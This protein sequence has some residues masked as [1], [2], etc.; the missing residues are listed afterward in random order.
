[1]SDDRQW[2]DRGLDAQPPALAERVRLFRLLVHDAALLRQ[3]LDRALAP[4]GL[5]TQQGALLQW[6]EAQP[7]APTIGA[8]ALA[9]GMTHQ[10]VKQIVTALERKG[11]IDITVD[12][13]DRRARRL[14]LTTHHRQFWKQRN[15]D[16]FAAVATWTAAWS[17]DEVS[18][19]V[20]LLRRLSRSL[21]SKPGGAEP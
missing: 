21:K 17:D 2:L 10:N 7:A 15:P 4:S 6:I 8:V 1:M 18:S 13:T 12:L 5:T 9:L 3:R 14:V 11:F 20:A 19:T 16:D